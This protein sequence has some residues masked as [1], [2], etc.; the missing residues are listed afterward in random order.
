MSEN[1]SVSDESYSDDDDD[2]ELDPRIQD[3]L[4]KLNAATNSINHLEAELDEARAVFRQTL[5]GATYQLN[6]VAHKLG[7]CVEK[8]RPFYEAYRQL[9]QSHSMLQKSTNQF[10]R[11]TGMHI[12]AKNRV[13]EAER[14]VFGGG[15]KRTFDSALQKMLNE[16]TIEVNEA[17]KLKRDSWKKHQEDL[18]AYRDLEAKVKQLYKKLKS[19][20]EKAKPYFEQKKEFDRHL[21]QLKLRV[22]S[23]HLGLSGAKENYSACLKSLEVISDDI[24]EKRKSKRMEAMIAKLQE[25]EA[26]VGADSSTEDETSLTASNLDLDFDSNVNFDKFAGNGDSMSFQGQMVGMTDRAVGGCEHAANTNSSFPSVPL[27]NRVVYGLE[28]PEDAARLG[29]PEKEAEPGKSNSHLADRES[30]LAEP[31][32]SE[33]AVNTEAGPTSSSENMVSLNEQTSEMDAPGIAN[34]TTNLSLEASISTLDNETAHE[35]NC[36]KDEE[37]TSDD[38]CVTITVDE[39]GSSDTM[40]GEDSAPAINESLTTQIEAE[41]KQKASLVEESEL[42]E[43][44]ETQSESHETQNEKTNKT[45]NAKNESQNDIEGRQILVTN[46]ETGCNSEQSVKEDEDHVKNVTDN[47]GCATESVTEQTEKHETSCE[48]ESNDNAEQDKEPSKEDEDNTKDVTEENEI[49][50]NVEEK[51]VTDDDTGA[52][53]ENITE[54]KESDTQLKENVEQGKEPTNEDNAENITNEKE[55]IENVEDKEVTNDNTG[56]NAENTTE[57]KESDSELKE[58]VEQEKRVSSDQA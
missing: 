31:T 58:N 22:D 56:G 42:F 38:F 13:S 35:E 41:N 7:K 16:A 14:R 33:S 46:E 53:A 19:P 8:S 21:W 44:Q 11:A 12:A 36:A 39:M 1:N 52:I 23:I 45:D 29:S 47:S 20:V 6:G 25:R 37:T 24:H 55:I 34:V 9:R 49:N 48:S 57:V 15:A 10:E 2:E 18:L 30:S 54:V 32:H 27:E 4:E 43:N 50:G 26:G 51:E 40:K 5:A 3:E 28:S 17:E